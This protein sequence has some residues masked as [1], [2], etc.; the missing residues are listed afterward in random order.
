M[1]HATQDVKEG[2]RILVATLGEK[3]A[4]TQQLQARYVMG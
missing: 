2:M 3:A 4:F 1:V